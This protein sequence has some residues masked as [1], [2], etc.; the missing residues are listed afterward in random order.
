MRNFVFKACLFAGAAFLAAPAIAQTEEEQV[1][2]AQDETSR[3]A[4]IVVT[5]VGSAEREAFVTPL[6]VSQVPSAQLRTFGSVNQADVLQQIPGLKAEGGGGEVATNLRVRGLPSGG[7]F[8]FTPLS[9]D[10]ITV[11][12]SFGLNSSAFDFFARNDLGID[13]LEYVR[14]GVSNLF[15]PGS[16]AGI[17]NYISK[18]GSDEDHGTVQVEV[19]EDDRFRGDFA[20]QGPIAE[21]TYYAVSGFY[22]YDEG[23]ID[24]GM[25]TEGFSLRGNLK[26]EFADGSGSV[27]LLGTYINDRVNFYLPLTLDGQSRERISGNDGATIYTHNSSAIAGLTSVTPEGVTEYRAADGFMTKG[28][29]IAAIFE[30]EI[31]SG[32]GLNVKAKWASFESS[33]NF[34]QAGV[35]ADSGNPESQADFLTNR[36]LTGAAVY[37]FSETGTALG[38]N[39]LLFENQFNDRQRPVTDATFETNLSNEFD[40]GTT[41]HTITIGGFVARAEADNI[42][43]SIRYLGDFTNNPALVDLTLDGDQYTVGGIVQAPS[44]YANQE[45]SVFRKALYFADQIDAGR[46]QFDVGA[47][48]ETA[49]VTNRFE[50][51]SNIAS[52]FT[53]NLV[54]GAPINTIRFGNGIYSDGEASATGWALAVGG[55]YELTDTVN[56]YANASR[57]YFFPQVQGTGGQ[58]ST[59]GD[60]QVYDEEPVYLA[61]AGVKLRTDRFN[62]SAAV[63]YSGL[64]DR[65]SVVFVGNDLTPVV[66]SLETD[67]YGVELDG[68]FEVN[69]YLKLNG[70]FTYQDH[71]VIESANASLIGNELNRLPNI[72]LNVGAQFNAGGFDAAAYWNYQGD[73]FA[74]QG[75]GIEL[76]AYSIARA[77]V[78]YSF[79]M[80]DNNDENLRVSLGVWNLFDSQGLAEGNPR[81]G[82][83]QTADADAI[84]FNGRPILPRRVTVKLTYDF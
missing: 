80:S 10:G 17:I 75:N 15:G 63:F 2:E 12:S 48:V 70:N 24:T 64:R 81:R 13:R 57:G 28:G 44:N 82:I 9:Y 52:G 78:G 37:T 77:E 6:A 51:T 30:K 3:L 61:E 66:N 34:F 41:T 40:I 43:R 45:R 83:T 8:E 31:G 14:G 1:A 18:E 69:D 65:N 53:G 50:G 55:L 35:G 49:E 72:L 4:T 29:S 16:V 27:K 76:D 56:L 38:A 46:W 62:G 26:K 22:R 33:S 23:P 19:A 47:R 36:G 68:T 20:F 25:P 74:D 58:I 21:D 39:D 7:Q 79:G 71:E 59:T 42:Q 73:S 32:W 60:I 5:G 67:T 11:I 54:A 84:Y